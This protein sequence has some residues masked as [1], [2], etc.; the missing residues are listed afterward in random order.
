LQY[1]LLL[2]VGRFS[3]RIALLCSERGLWL[4][5]KL[6]YSSTN[7]LCISK[8]IFPCHVALFPLIDFFSCKKYVGQKRNYTICFIRLLKTIILVLYLFR[9]KR[10][11]LSMLTSI[12]ALLTVQKI[13][14][15]SIE[16]WKNFEP[17]RD[18]LI[19][20]EPPTSLDMSPI[21]IKEEQRLQSLSIME[22]WHQNIGWPFKHRES[23]STVIWEIS[24][25]F[26]AKTM[27][28]LPINC[29]KI[30]SLL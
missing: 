17:L 15:I 25:I 21:I 19:S 12:Y 20:K 6:F 9:L 10:H 23:Q 2:V 4:F 5:K 13:H 11:L 22:T 28:T 30:L 18:M 29:T 8:L 24:S 27:G 16:L 7:S 14:Q 26:H 1:W 3:A